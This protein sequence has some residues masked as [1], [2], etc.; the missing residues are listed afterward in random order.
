MRARLRR[1]GFPKFLRRYLGED[2]EEDWADQVASEFADGGGD[3][4][5]TANPFKPRGDAA[6][7]AS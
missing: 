5:T 3:D 6:E 7:N 2:F 1:K 4:R